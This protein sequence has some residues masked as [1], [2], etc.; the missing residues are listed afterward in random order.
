ML[1]LIL[2]RHGRAAADDIMLGGQLDVPLTADGRAEAQAL[3]R[4]LAGVRIDRIVASPM[5]RTLETAQVVAA[6][7]PIEVDERLR[8]LD[9]GRWEGLT[10]PEVDAHDPELRARWEHDPAATHAPGGE[11]GDDVATRA[12]GFL[13]DLLAAELP[14]PADSAGGVAAG[15]LG[16]AAGSS[17]VGAARRHSPDPGGSRAIV[18]ESQADASG[19]RRVLVVAHGTFNRILMCVALGVPVRDYRRR[20]LQDRTNLTVLLY[21]RGDTPDGAQLALA[22]DIAH[23]RSPGYPPWG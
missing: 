12:L 20:F 17:G 23:L 16:G 10:Y 22:N 5:A 18:S 13:V 4:R 11:S 19:E 14:A 8:E 2:T 7:R 6:G 9:Y 3:G 1:T 15:P 21:E